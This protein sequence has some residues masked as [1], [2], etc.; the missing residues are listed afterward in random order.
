M[1][2]SVLPELRYQSVEFSSRGVAELSGNGHAEFVARSAVHRIELVRQSVSEHPGRELGYAIA[3]ALFSVAYWINGGLIGPVFLM[4]LSAWMLWH[5]FHKPFLLIVTSGSSKHVLRF[6]GRV[7]PSSLTAF[8]QRA[9]DT[10]E[11]EIQSAVD[12]V[13]ILRR[14]PLAEASGRT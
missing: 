9:S 4:A 1:S 8:L 14:K 10:Y 11:Y 12:G 6:R 7:E 5:V 3:L 2:E 13:G